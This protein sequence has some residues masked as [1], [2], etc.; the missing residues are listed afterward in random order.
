MRRNHSSAATIGKAPND[1]KVYGTIV[2]DFSQ[3]EYRQAIRR[4]AVG[5]QG[6]T[7]EGDRGR[8]DY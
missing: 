5:K 3:E 2:R 8:E 1:V 4:A 6:L 7:N